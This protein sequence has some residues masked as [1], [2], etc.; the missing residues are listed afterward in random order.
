LRGCSIT[1]SFSGDVPMM[2]KCGCGKSG[3]SSGKNSSLFPVIPAGELRDKITIEVSSVVS[4]SLGGGVREWSPVAT[5]W[6]DVQ[7]VSPQQAA[8]IKHF[9]EQQLRYQQHY[10]VLLRYG[11]DID[12]SMRL[13]Y[14]RKILWI[15]S[16]VNKDLLNWQINLWCK[17]GPNQLP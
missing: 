2:F 15:Y 10:N 13:I 11:P 8:N 1:F 17:E 9:E 12:T 7:T 5:V 14:E 3:K 4:D 6:G 16:V